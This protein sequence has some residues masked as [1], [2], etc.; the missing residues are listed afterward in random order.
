MND[1]ELIKR[2]VRKTTKLSDT[3]SRVSDIDYD[4]K[5]LNKR[6]GSYKTNFEVLL[7]EVE[8]LRAENKML[9]DKL[10]EC[11]AGGDLEIVTKTLCILKS[12]TIN[13]N[14]N[15]IEKVKGGLNDIEDRFNDSSNNKSHNNPEENLNIPEIANPSILYKTCINNLF[16]IIK[17]HSNTP[18]INKEPTLAKNPLNNDSESNDHHNTIDPNS[19]YL[20]MNERNNGLDLIPRINIE[21]AYE[22]GKEFSGN[23][24][25]CD[26][27]SLYSNNSIFNMV[28]EPGNRLRTENKTVSGNGGFDFYW[29]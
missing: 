19:P 15:L 11:N 18:Q 29:I 20:A 1:L 4:Y 14:E 13:D 27:V 26:N 2:N 10:K 25:L 12:L 28:S 21:C 16:N 9:K 5:T 7:G 3:E 22:S 8:E 17:E 23:K 24:S 6:L